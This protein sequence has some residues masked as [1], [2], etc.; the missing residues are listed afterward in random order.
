V[1]RE[2]RPLV[3]ASAMALAAMVLT[4]TTAAQELLP[5]DTSSPPAIAP[6][7]LPPTPPPSPAV[8]PESAT[9]LALRQ[10]KPLAL[11]QEPPHSSAGWNIAA[12]VVIGLATAFYFRKRRPPR[13]VE[14]AQLTIVR[15]APLGPRS[16]LVVVNVEGQ[17]LLLGVTPQSIQ[18]LAV[19][20]S[21][22]ETAPAPELEQS[23]AP[24]VNDRFAAMLRAADGRTETKAG[25]EDDSAV[26]GQAR[27]LLGLRRR[28]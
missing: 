23:D 3:V 1:N 21:D 14:D 11:A 15:R 9:P 7:P 10:A 5:K 22:E 24:S 16:E 26:A 2:R 18:S 8:A 13:R 6:S 17:R 19:L 25:V 12:V 20:D 4:P 28:G 27:G